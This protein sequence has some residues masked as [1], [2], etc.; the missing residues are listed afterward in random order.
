MHRPPIL[1][2][3]SM[4]GQP[5]TD[6]ED[7]LLIDHIGDEID[8]VEICRRHKRLPRGILHRALFNDFDLEFIKGLDTPTYKELLNIQEKIFICDPILH[9]QDT[10]C[11]FQTH[12]TSISEKLANL[13]KRLNLKQ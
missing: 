6:E 5:W 13:E 7:E 10:L 2:K 8:I 3:Y 4:T 12:L 1:Q 11:Q 9:I